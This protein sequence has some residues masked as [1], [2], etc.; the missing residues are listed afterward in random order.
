MA[1]PRGLGKGLEALLDS[2]NIEVSG[3][4]GVRMVQLSLVE[5]NPD[6]PRKRFIDESL[7]ALA[8]NIKENG[9]LQPLLVREAKGR[10]EIIAGERR[11]RASRM[12]G[13]IEVPVV[14]KSYDDLKTLEIALVENLQRE[15]LNAIEQAKGYKLLIERFSLT[16]EELAKRV[17]KSRSSVANAM[18]LLALPDDILQL[19][20]EGDISEGHARALLPLEIEFARK[21]AHQI[22]ADDLSVRQTER[23][24]K[25]PKKKEKEAVGAVDYDAV[26]QKRLE[27]A[28]GRKITVKSGAKRGKI[29]IEYGGNDDL[30]ELLERL[31]VGE[32]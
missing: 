28:F 11:W 3:G 31:G 27:S 5:P 13:L 22:V 15:D 29:T 32:E 2:S 4:D 19:V 18:R 21:L 8:D 24:A 26:L 14:V 10:Y 20:E 17:G 1:K 23:I 30:Q 6:Q 16:Q 12:A 7:R 9:V 25:A